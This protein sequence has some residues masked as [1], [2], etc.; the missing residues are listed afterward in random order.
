[1]R[2]EGGISKRE[3]GWFDPFP[4]PASRGVAISR[5]EFEAAWAQQP[6]LP[7]P[8]LPEPRQSLLNRLRARWR[9][10]D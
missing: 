7:E 2:R 1:V 4:P 8:A 3:Y 9:S 10:S 5:K 6:A